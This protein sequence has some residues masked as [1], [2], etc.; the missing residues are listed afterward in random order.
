MSFDPDKQQKS[1]S[2]HLVPKMPNLDVLKCVMFKDGTFQ[3]WDTS[4]PANAKRFQGVIYRSSS[5]EYRVASSGVFLSTLAPGIWYCNASGDL[6][7]T[8]PSGSFAHEVGEQSGDFFKVN[9]VVSTGEAPILLD[10]IEIQKAI[11]GDA[12]ITQRVNQSQARWDKTAVTN[13]VDEV[14]SGGAI[15]YPAQTS[16]VA[17]TA[18]AGTCDTYLLHQKSVLYHQGF[19]NFISGTA[20][21]PVTP[22]A[23]GDYAYFGGWDAVTSSGFLL[24]FHNDGLAVGHYRYGS[25]VGPLVKQVDFNGV[26][27]STLVD[28]TKTAIYRIDYGWF[29]S[30]PIIFEVSTDD[31]KSWHVF[32]TIKYM[33]TETAT[34]VP[35][36]NLKQVM[37][38]KK[39]SGDATNVQIVSA[40]WASGGY[41]DPSAYRDYDKQGRFPFHKT[42]TASAILLGATVTAH[43]ITA[44][45][46]A[47]IQGYTAAISG[48]VSV[49]SIADFEANGEVFDGIL[50]AG[51]TNQTRSAADGSAERASNP[52][53]SPGDGGNINLVVPPLGLDSLV[54]FTVWGYE[55]IVE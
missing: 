4:D 48:D 24:E 29:G 1:A 38:V 20:A 9:A 10:M 54:K 28:P 44:G 8:F 15:T 46:K 52:Y 6:T 5:G 41:N 35:S 26:D 21:C 3:P 12:I 19:P 33:N 7:Q 25:L 36:P 45:R 11:F 27:I 55:E 13:G 49:A 43:T 22:V 16:T 34:S 14:V 37:G 47:F 18:T 23:A 30:S 51:V 32:H 50:V 40:S 2:H 31:G 17:V 39:T 42:V 53:F